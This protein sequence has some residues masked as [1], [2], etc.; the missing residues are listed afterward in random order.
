VTG[1]PFDFLHSESGHWAQNLVP[2][3]RGFGGTIG[4]MLNYA[5][6]Q[7]QMIGAQV[8]FYMSLGLVACIYS[9]VKLPASYTLWSIA[10]WLLFASVSW[11][12]SGPR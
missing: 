4:V 12:L 5:P 9:A 10:N 2:P 3:W 11:D 8:L 1:S 7:S 6:S